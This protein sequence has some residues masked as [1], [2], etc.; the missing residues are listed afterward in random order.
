MIQLPFSSN[1]NDEI[2]GFSSAATLDSL[3]QLSLKEKNIL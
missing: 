3:F 2:M 1:V